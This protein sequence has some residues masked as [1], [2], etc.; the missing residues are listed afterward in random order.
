MDV[1]QVGPCGARDDK[2]SMVALLNV[3]VCDKWSGHELRFEGEPLLMED[4][5]S[6]TL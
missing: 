2:V 4:A 6:A 5:V 3:F 1:C